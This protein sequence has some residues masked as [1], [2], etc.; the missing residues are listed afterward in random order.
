M[1]KVDWKKLVP[2][3]FAGETAPFGVHPN[4]KQRAKK[5]F[6]AAMHSDVT[7][8][9]ILVEAKRYLRSQGVSKD[10]VSEELTRIKRFTAN[11]MK[12]KKLG[13]AWLITK[14][15]T[16]ITGEVIAI[17][18]YRKSAD[19][20]REFVENLYISENYGLHEK[21]TYARNRRNNP[22][23]AKFE[24]I[25]DVPLQGRITCGHNPFLLGRPVT[26]LVIV[27]ND[28]ESEKLEWKEIPHTK[29][30]K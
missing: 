2:G 10:G 22:Y 13:R 19:R 8:N 20:V 25:N 9:D 28:L 12:K 15:G 21:L 23:P 3:C 7:M 14:E 5:M 30:S 24:R 16:E 4:D 11:P 29:M 27:S 17:L 18:D 1:E 6:R 26:D